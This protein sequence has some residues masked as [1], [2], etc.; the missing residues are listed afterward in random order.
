MAAV[1]ERELTPAQ[2]AILQ[3]LDSY[4]ASLLAQHP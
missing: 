4:A 3:Q 1:R 2:Q